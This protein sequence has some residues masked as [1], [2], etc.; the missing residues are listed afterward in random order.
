MVIFG[1]DVHPVYQAGLNIESLPSAGIDF[2]SVKVSQGTSASYL[3]QGSLNFLHRGMACGLI[4]MGYHYLVPG[5]EDAQAATFAAALK[6]VGGNLPGI[7]DV[8]ALD[9]NGKPSLTIASIRAFHDAC[10]RRG[11]NVPLMYLPHWY[12]VEIGSPDLS[13]LPALWASS[14]PTTTPG[15]PYQLYSN[16]RPSHWQPYGGRPVGTLQFGDSAIL[17]SYQ[18][19]DVNAF[20]G[21]RAALQQLLGVTTTR[22]PRKK[23]HMSY[24]ISP[25]PVPKDASDS[26]KPD[27]TWPVTE[28]TLTS[29]GPAGGWAGRL[30]MHLT[31]GW[32]GTFIQEAWSAPSGTHFVQRYDP[33][34]KTGGQFVDAFV[35]QSWELPAGDRA[36]IVRLANP[37]IASVSP[38]TEH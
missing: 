20:P 25:T 10:R 35:T 31:P 16:V 24:L 28:Y 11:V 32:R 6:R 27:G 14:Y 23:T 15:T 22:P 4:C 5:N 38:E 8:E 13:G 29:P 7:S 18:P 26:A 36:L 12:W 21:T 19:V 33:V 3:D 17:G 34:A 9:N 2:L 37:T 1:A 30:L